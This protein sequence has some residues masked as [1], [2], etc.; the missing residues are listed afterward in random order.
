MEMLFPI[1]VLIVIA[2]IVLAYYGY[3]AEKKRREALRALADRWGMDWS[4]KDPLGIAGRYRYHGVLNEGDDRY[5]Y[6]VFHGRRNGRETVCFDYHYETHSTDS[7]G[8]RTTTHH[9]LS[10]I[11]VIPGANFPYLWVRPEGF[12]DRMGELVGIDDIDFESAEF[13]RKFYV[14]S[15]DKKFAYDIFHPRAMEFML[16]RPVR[17]SMEFKS[18][19]VLVYD[20]RK[21][22]PEDYEAALGL[23]EGLLELV[24]GFVWEERGGGKSPD[25]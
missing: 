14:K 11:L 12:L 21:W 25:S 4:E 24:P 8:H 6:N 22:K 18:P 9:H 7:K 1:L 2:V 10:A 23:I 16:S 13:S 5:A 19:T 3:Q 17:F 20:N 15:P